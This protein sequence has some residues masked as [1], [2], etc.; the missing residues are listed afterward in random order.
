[1]YSK[2]QLQHGH[3]HLGVNICICDIHNPINKPVGIQREQNMF[4]C[5]FSKP[6]STDFTFKLCE[7]TRKTLASTKN[8]EMCLRR[9]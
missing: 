8:F 9:Q 3:A 6:G 1:M 4:K 7:P 2:H 5:L